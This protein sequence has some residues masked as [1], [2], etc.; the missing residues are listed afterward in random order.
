MKN[1]TFIL[2]LV[3]VSILSFAGG[4]NKSISLFNLHNQAIQFALNG[5]D[6]IV[7]LHKH[8]IAEG[9]TL[10]VVD[11]TGEVVV[12]RIYDSYVSKD[13]EIAINELE[14]GNYFLVLKTNYG[15]LYRLFSV[16]DDIINNI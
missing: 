10:Q 11:K 7:V 4:E 13:E 1:A 5:E 15:T 16:S 14:R 2:L 9:F 12:E 6:N 8:R 3:F